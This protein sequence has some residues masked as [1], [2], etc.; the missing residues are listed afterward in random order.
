MKKMKDKKRKSTVLRLYILIAIAGIC[1]VTAVAYFA[2]HT[3]KDAFVKGESK[4]LMSL[5]ETGALGLKEDFEEKEN[6]ILSI[7]GEDFISTDLFEA[8][9]D[10][11]F[12]D[13]NFYTSKDYEY[14]PDFKREQCEKAVDEPEKVISGPTVYRYGGYYVFYMTKSVSIAGEQVGV[15]QFEWNLSSFF[16]QSETL[17][18]IEINNNGYC[19]VKTGDGRI[20][21]SK[22]DRAK[23]LES[24][25][26][27]GET[28]P[29]GKASIGIYPLYKLENGVPSRKN[30]L[31]SAASIE[32]GDELFTVCVVEDYGLLVRPI[33]TLSIYLITSVAGIF[34]WIMLSL[35]LYMRTEKRETELRLRFEFEKTLEKQD[36]LL[37]IYNRDKEL[38]SLWGALAHEFNNQM[39]P[40]LL[41]SE[42]FK[43]NRTVAGLLPEETEE[44]YKVAEHCSTLSRQMLQFSRAGRSER[45][46]EEFNASQE[47][48][49]S[50][51]MVER[52]IPDNV[53]FK[54]FVSKKDFYVLGYAGMLSQIILNLSNNALRALK[55]KEKGVLEITFGR[56]RES[57]KYVTLIVEDNG[58]G[59]PEDIR[60]HI[61]EPFFSTKDPEEGG[62]IGLTVVSRLLQENG[63]YIEAESKTGEG[64]RFTAA[65]PCIIK[66]E[67][68]D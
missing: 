24:S 38:T 2:F 46:R 56:S 9:K 7:Y 25:A 18:G 16:N 30:F 29:G 44:L 60:K 34:A 49:L 36:E 5:A 20:V 48:R 27:F 52:L 28:S 35:W 6:L 54:Y 67:E 53:D 3:V 33:E 40:I 37:R 51:R 22:D 19:Y 13:K 31:A 45:K 64:S 21:M 58:T 65:L 55:D 1:A 17:S 66:Q 47:V 8:A 10:K 57:D 23:E 62:G 61:F 26:D 32:I 42:L 15:L 50:L 59:I 43:N 39:T 68:A 41:Y 63:G 11:I 12:C 4:S 14:L